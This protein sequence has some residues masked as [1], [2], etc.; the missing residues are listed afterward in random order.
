MIKNIS[1]SALKSLLYFGIAMGILLAIWLLMSKLTN[2]EIPSPTDTL[3]TF[4]EVIQNPLQNDPDIT[5][6]GTKLLSSLSRVA[7]GFGLGCLVAIPL[8]LIM[9]NSKTVMNIFNPIVQLLKPVS[10]LA[11]FPLGL[12]IFQNSPKASVFM[13]FICC[14]WPIVINTSFGVASIPNDHKNVSKAFGFSICKYITKIMI[15]YTLPHIFTG[16]KLSIGIAWMVIVAG[17]MLSGGQG[18]GYFVWEE[19]FNGG[20]TAKILVAIIIIG[21]IGLLLDKLFSAIQKKF[22]YID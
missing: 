17:E 2:N 16:L 14:I 21:I 3:V 15:P 11:W 10:P 6:I 5:G 4:K 19:G 18:I 9:G 1:T 12:A 22:S 20:S 13:I 7:V 8:G